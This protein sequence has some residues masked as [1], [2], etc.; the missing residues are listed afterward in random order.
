MCGI[1][2]FLG[3]FESHETLAARA[4]AMAD[5]LHHR[6]PDDSGVWTDPDSGV[7]LAH[8]RLSIVDLS[9]EG[10]QPMA[11][12][13]GRYQIVFNG[14]IYNFNALRQE[15]EGVG[16]NHWRGH[17]DTEVMLAAISR[18]GVEGA[19]KRFVGMFAFALWDRKN[20]SL[21]LARDRLGEKPLYYGRQGGLLLFASELKAL[22]AH[23]A[24][25]P[26][27]TTA[28][29]PCYCA[30]AI[31]PHPTASTVASTSCPPAPSSASRRM[32]RPTPGRWPTGLPSRAP[33]RGRETPSTAAT[34]RRWTS[35]S[36]C[37]AV[38]W[39]ARWWPMSLSAP[40]S[41]AEWTPPP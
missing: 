32:P 20:R 11:S 6:G 34:R 18:W 33:S 22:R 40:S 35:W 30:T 27:S 39:R 25:V 8:R 38:L 26:R 19:L 37:W 31:S 24:S 23:P 5:T 21:T 1:A 36:G 13:C 14:E 9:S 17:S 28:P 29:S 41:P 10:H 15:L 7:A 4:R 3:E 16:D 12:A 2:G